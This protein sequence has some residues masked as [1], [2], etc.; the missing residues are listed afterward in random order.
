MKRLIIAFCTLTLVFQSCDEFFSNVKGEGPIIKESRNVT[1]FKGVELRASGDV[2][3]KQ[4]TEFKVVV[5][6]HKNIAE[7]L[8]TVVENGVLNIRF[9]DKMGSVSVEKLNIYIEAPAFD[10]INLLGSGNITTENALTGSNLELDLGGSGNI[11]VKDATF[12][13][14]DA[15]IAGSGSIELSGTADS[16]NLG[17]S[18]SGNI[19]AKNLKAKTVKANITGSGGIDCYAETDLDATITGSGN[20]E[21]S[22]TPSVKTRI[23]GSGNVEKH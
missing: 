1:G 9:K 11:N 20:I 12:N 19:E 13:K 5:E 2:F 18:G 15:D 7:I 8:E 10:K 17:V 23:T 16:D 21:Y 22:G 14:I 6:T 4:G 3:I